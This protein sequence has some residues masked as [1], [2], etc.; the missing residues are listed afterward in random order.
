M[1]KLNE[2]YV[3]YDAGLI[4]TGDFEQQRDTLLINIINELKVMTCR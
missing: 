3:T 2:L 1:K 4:S